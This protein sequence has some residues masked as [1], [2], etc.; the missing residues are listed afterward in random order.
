MV[1]AVLSTTVTIAVVV[2][3][4]LQSSVTVKV[5]VFGPRSAQVK[6]VWLAASVTV[7]HPSLEPLSMSPAT[8]VPFPL[9]FR[10][11]V[12]SLAKAVGLV[13]S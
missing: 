10:V 3:A 13:V 2:D 7:L 5:M 4:L 11:T 12:W 6:L 1:G 8:I 9:A